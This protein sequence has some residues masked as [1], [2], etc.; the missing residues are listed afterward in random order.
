[1]KL[2]SGKIIYRIRRCHFKLFGDVSINVVTTENNVSEFLNFFSNNVS[3]FV[4]M[5]K[6]IGERIAFGI[7]EE[8]E[9]FLI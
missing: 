2:T 1:M 6:K 8:L 4:E 5:V 3:K 7:F 9:K